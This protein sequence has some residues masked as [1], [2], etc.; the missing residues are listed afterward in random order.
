MK[1]ALLILALMTST[2]VFSYEVGATTQQLTIVP[3]LALSSSFSNKIYRE[4]AV[5]I[6]NDGNEY[7]LNGS[8]SPYLSQSLKA[9]Q[10]NN[11]DMSIDESVDLLME[12][13]SEI[14]NSN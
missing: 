2:Q 8:I 10:E 7:M 6:L 13:A 9:L 4:E 14:L 5:A 3:F 11:S 1:T 12:R